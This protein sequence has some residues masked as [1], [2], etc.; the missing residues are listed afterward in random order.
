MISGQNNGWILNA[1]VS[2][3]VLVARAGFGLGGLGALGARLG[4]VVV[5]VEGLDLRVDGLGRGSGSRLFA[6][7]V[8]RRER[9]PGS[10]VVEDD[11]VVVGGQPWG[12]YDL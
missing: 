11:L 1:H 12:S 6:V 5:D 8:R 7:L 10:V 2:L 3:L 9:V 4:L